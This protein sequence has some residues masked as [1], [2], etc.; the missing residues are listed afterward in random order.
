MAAERRSSAVNLSQMAVAMTAYKRPQYLARTLDSWNHVSGVSSLATFR[1]A[2]EP[3]AVEAEMV[4]TVGRHWELG[5][6]VTANGRRLGVL[7]NPVEAVTSVFESYS[8][9]E[10]VI[11]AEEDIVVSSDVLTYM[12]WAAEEFGGSKD[13]AL[14][15][16]MPRFHGDDPHIVRKYPYM[17]SNLVWGT[18][19]GWWTNLIEPTWDRDYSTGTAEQ[20]GSGWDFHLDWRVLPRNGLVS[21]APDMSRSQHIGEFDGEHCSAAEF[22]LTQVP[23]FRDSFPPGVFRMEET[24]GPA[25]SS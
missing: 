5:A 22:P 12:K 8:Q 7:V 20:P 17:S 1:I 16:S 6:S 15:C 14:V 2:L 25:R 9:V 3:S 13:V 4:E 21:V 18:W 10:F 19:R 23:S 11:L 24:H